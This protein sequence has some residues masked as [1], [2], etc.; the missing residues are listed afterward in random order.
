MKKRNVNNAAIDDAIELVKKSKDTH[1]LLGYHDMDGILRGKYVAR[2]SFESMARSGFGACGVILGWGYGE[3]PNDD[4]TFTGWHT[5]FSDIELSIIPESGIPLSFEDNRMFFLA[6]FEGSAKE[7]CPRNALRRV[8]KKAEDCGYKFMSGIEYEFFMFN[9]TSSSAYEKGYRNLQ[10]LSQGNFSYS[11]LR[12][13]VNSDLVSEIL[14][15]FSTMGIPI[16]GL[17]TEQGPGVLEVALSVSDA[18]KT[19]DNAALFRSFLKIMA[20]KRG[21]MATFMAKWNSELAGQ[22][23]HTH[24]SLLD[25]DNKPLFYDPEDVHGMSQQMRHFIGGQLT[26]LPELACMFA[27]NVN[28]Y[29]RLLPGTWAPV[30]AN[31]GIDNRTVAVRVLGGSANSKRLEFRVPGSDANPYLALSAA[32]A[33]GLWGIEN[34]VDP[35]SP[36]I[37]NGYI[38][39]TCLE[40]RLP[41]TLDEAADRFEASEV[42]RELFGDKFVS[43][44]SQMRR[45]EAEQSR[46]AVTDWQLQRYFEVV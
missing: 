41:Q 17:H 24:L 44:F 6:D 45:F 13:S 14:T 36:V 29:A 42:A 12:T 10:P 31:W 26:L 32:I 39:E 34:R 3:E 11:P 23:G 9:E 40:R 20:Q 2:E 8:L 18:L 43:H 25:L 35:G 5:G 15:S 33:A 21:L 30:S 46:S 4:C 1:V 28:S 38:E 19:A 7:I 22:S 16:E 27:P 37:G